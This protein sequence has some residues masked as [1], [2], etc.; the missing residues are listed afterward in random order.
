MEIFRTHFG[1]AQTGNVHFKL[2]NLRSGIV[3]MAQFLLERKTRIKKD[4]LY[5]GIYLVTMY[6]T[7]EETGEAL[8]VKDIYLSS[9][10]QIPLTSVKS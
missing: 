4:F 10:I 3:S 2:E 7:L 1:A 8:P 5:L 6:G 9:R